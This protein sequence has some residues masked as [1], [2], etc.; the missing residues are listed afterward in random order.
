MSS[1]LAV[2]GFAA[3]VISVT[4]LGSVQ[5]AA[6]AKDP[7]RVVVNGI[8]NGTG[9][10]PYDIQGQTFWA[11][12][13]LFNALGGKVQWEGDA[14]RVESFGHSFVIAPD[15]GTWRLDGMTRGLPRETFMHHGN[16]YVPLEEVVTSLGCSYRYDSYTKTA[17]I[18]TPK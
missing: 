15:E 18:E 12:G 4:L 16:L 2:V 6:L 1:S 13:P 14:A 17:Y 5:T 10:I 8:P 9:P 3:L 7:I 11:I